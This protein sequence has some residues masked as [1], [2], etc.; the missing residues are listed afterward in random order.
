[1]NAKLVNAKL[2]NAKL[3]NGSPGLV[4][5]LTL[6]IPF[7]IFVRTAFGARLPGEDRLGG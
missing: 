7:A 6:P 4:G 5:I 1:V 2:V 3:V